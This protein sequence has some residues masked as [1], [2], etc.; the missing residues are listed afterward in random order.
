LSSGLNWR[1]IAKKKKKKKKKK[2]RTITTKKKKK[3]KHIPENI[4]QFNA[5]GRYFDKRAEEL[6]GERIF[7]YGEGDDE[8]SLEE[9]FS[10][11]EKDLWPKLVKA[12]GIDISDVGSLDDQEIEYSFEIAYHAAETAAGQAGLRAPED[13]GIESKTVTHLGRVQRNVELHTSKSDRSCRHVEIDLS[14]T[15]LSYESGDHLA[16]YPRNDTHL[17]DQLVAL[18]ARNEGDDETGNIERSDVFQLKPTRKDAKRRLPIYCSVDT[19]LSYYCDLTSAAP[20]RFIKACGEL[21]TDPKE[22]ERLR[23]AGSTSTEAGRALYLD[24]VVRPQRS[25]IELLQQFRS[26]R[27][28]LVRFLELS[29]PLHPRY[30]S[31]A[32]SPRKSAREA[33]LCAAIVEYTTAG[34]RLTKG[35]ATHHLKSLGEGDKFCDIVFLVFF[36]FL[37]FLVFLVSNFPICFRESLGTRINS[38]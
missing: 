34:G 3:K 35:V 26:V 21:A 38:H 30:Y 23:A 15:S 9:D 7:R 1:S 12:H 4:P 27:M 11:W 10:A 20:V 13:T 17:V 29:P 18:L 5:M 25:V 2:K 6:G 32:S 19:A 24:L 31:I 22:A 33:H 8:G 37:V 36:G 16:V 28:P 14:S